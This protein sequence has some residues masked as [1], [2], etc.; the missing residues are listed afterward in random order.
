MIRKLFTDKSI[1]CE[2]VVKCAV[3][4]TKA[5]LVFTNDIVF[6]YPFVKSRIEDMA[7]QFTTN[8]EK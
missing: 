6:F 8:V 4:F 7:I 2:D 1:K 3:F 5:R